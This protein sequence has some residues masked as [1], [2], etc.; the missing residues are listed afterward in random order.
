MVVLIVYMK[1]RNQ[2]TATRIAG[3]CPCGFTIGEPPGRAM[4][5]S[6]YLLERVIEYATYPLSHT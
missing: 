3:N 5:P 4:G 1:G 6:D 2:Q